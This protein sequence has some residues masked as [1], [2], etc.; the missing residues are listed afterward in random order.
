M[1]V[2]F[3]K[4]KLPYLMSMK[5][6]ACSVSIRVLQRYETRDFPDKMLQS[7]N[8]HAIYVKGPYRHDQSRLSKGHGI[9]V[10]V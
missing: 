8:I 9:D 3:T 6:I 7:M 5:F 10:L 2:S 1:E 4:G